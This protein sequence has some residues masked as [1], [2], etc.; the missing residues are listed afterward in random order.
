[1]ILVSI[2]CPEHF[3]T[4]RIFRQVPINRAV[5]S[6]WKIR[7]MRDSKKTHNFGPSV[8]VT[9]GVVITLRQSNHNYENYCVISS[10][11]HYFC[12]FEMTFCVNIQH[13]HVP[14]TV[15]GHHHGNLLVFC[16]HIS[17][18]SVFSRFSKAK[19]QQK[20]KWNENDN[21]NS[22]KCPQS[23]EQSS[24]VT[25]STLPNNRNCEALIIVTM[26]NR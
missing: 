6:E 22:K 1:M 18:F 7:E 20:L 12:R 2:L 10:F 13:M 3:H 11:E 24:L 5:Q 19:T 25:F 8:S 15:C 17:I 9:D 4:N 16:L 23:S 21:N 26:L 14:Q